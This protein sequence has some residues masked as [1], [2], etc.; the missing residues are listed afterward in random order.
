MKRTLRIFAQSLK[1]IN[2]N[3]G[4]SFLTM[5]GIIIGIAS[6]ISLV[7]IGNG[8]SNRVTGRISSLGTTT[9][10]VRSGAAP[11]GANAGGGLAASLGGGT[12]RAVGVQDGGAR[13]GFRQQT[14]TLTSA[15]LQAIQDNSKSWGIASAAAYT[16]SNSELTLAG[17]DSSGNNQKQDFTVSGAQPAYFD[18]QSLTIS[19]GRLFA[20]S[21]VS[22]TSKVA[23]LGAQAAT[24]LFDTASPIGKTITLE[25]DTYTVVGVLGSKEQSGF[26]NSNRQIF[27]PYTAAQGTYSLTNISAIYAKATSESTVETAKTEVSNK[28]LSLHNKT[29]KTADFSVSTS[30]DLLN[31][32]KQSSQVFTTLL[33]G[34]ASISLVVGGI[35]IM[36]IML[37]AV[38]ERTREIGL[39]KALGARTRDI[40]Q[41]F[42]FE[43][44]LLCLA[45]GLIGIAVGT[46]LAANLGSVLNGINPQVS[47]SSVILSVAVSTAVGLVFGIYPAA[48]AARLNPIDALRY[49]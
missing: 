42:I 29:D 19:T 49:E 8:A 10:T 24:D 16:S 39:R 48:K 28:L 40:L 31:T 2:R 21:D 45:G 25:S 35:G 23:V 33:A 18:I 27:V 38:T 17:K 1:A 20:D 11:T 44:V 30:E 46:L 15:D 32:I 7:A 47:A 13:G 22:S 6:V 36:N 34:I 37:V 26:D 41:Q 12:P 9:I 43:S 3:K 5:L 14:P 4:R